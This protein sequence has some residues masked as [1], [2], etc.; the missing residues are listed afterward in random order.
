M[1]IFIYLYTYINIA[2]N[3]TEEKIQRLDKL[4]TGYLLS[5]CYHNIIVL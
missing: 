5:V 1:Y 2:L 3:C 4:P